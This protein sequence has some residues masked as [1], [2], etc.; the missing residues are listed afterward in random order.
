MPEQAARY[1]ADAWEDLIRD[2]V[3]NKTKVTV[4]EVARNA[5]QIETPKI[6]T[7]DQRRITAALELIGWKRLP[8]D[9]EGKRWW[10]KA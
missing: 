4:G 2:Y 5:L 9:W 10:T 7:A 6:G 8:V 1:E 3:S